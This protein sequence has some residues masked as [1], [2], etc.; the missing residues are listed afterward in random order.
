MPAIWDRIEE[1]IS[2]NKRK[3]YIKYISVA[4]AV[5]IIAI[6]VISQFI[7][8]D[9]FTSSPLAIENIENDDIKRASDIQLITSDEKMTIPAILPRS[10]T[11]RKK[12]SL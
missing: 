8:T 1:S 3:L 10:I 2:P 4:A 7:N 12:E 9:Q 6:L 11:V 5:A